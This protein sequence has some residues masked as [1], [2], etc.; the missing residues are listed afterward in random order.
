MVSNKNIFI[1][2]EKE[3]KMGLFL[4]NKGLIILFEHDLW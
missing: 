3:R 1:V 2:N 4:S